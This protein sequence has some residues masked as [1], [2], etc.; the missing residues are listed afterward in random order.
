M[1]DR[2]DKASNQLSMCN[3]V[4]ASPSI[5]TLFHSIKQTPQIV[6]SYHEHF[7][8]VQ[9]PYVAPL[10]LQAVS[11]GGFTYSKQEEEKMRDIERYIHVQVT[12]S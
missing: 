4:N 7:C 5:V 8:C 11:G 1:E 12:P 9:D 10:Q 6:A 3:C 2:V